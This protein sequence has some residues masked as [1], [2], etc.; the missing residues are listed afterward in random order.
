MLQ[1]YCNVNVSN[2][3]VVHLK[4]TQSYMSSISTFKN[5]DKKID[6]KPL[7][8]QTLIKDSKFNVSLIYLWNQI[9]AV[10]EEGISRHLTSSS[11]RI[12]FPG[13]SAALPSPGPRAKPC[14][15]PLLTSLSLSGELSMPRQSLSFCTSRHHPHP[16]ANWISL[17]GYVKGTPDTTCEIS[18]S[19][20]NSSS[21]SLYPVTQPDSL[22]TVP[23]SVTNTIIYLDIIAN[24]GFTFT[25]PLVSSSMFPSSPN[26]TSFHLLKTSSI[27]SPLSGFTICSLTQSTI[28]LAGIFL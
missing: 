27:F 17:L 8:F 13:S 24:R 7:K 19:G 6:N 11:S 18:N 1:Y 20:P 3:H 25:F 15:C 10:R 16:F 26:S 23:I 14:L 2:Q 12:T 21:Q 9:G 28:S 4:L 5:W 22:P